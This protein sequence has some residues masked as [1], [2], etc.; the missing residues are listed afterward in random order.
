MSNSVIILCT[1]LGT[2]QVTA[3][4]FDTSHYQVLLDTFAENFTYWDA[5]CRSKPI[6]RIFHQLKYYLNSLKFEER[7]VKL[8]F[9]T[10]LNSIR[11]W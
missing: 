10:L 1:F 7:A 3:A 6:V 5:K 2:L 8:S 4:L 9:N 11:S